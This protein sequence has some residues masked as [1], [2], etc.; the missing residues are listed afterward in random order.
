M[1]PPPP[2][3]KVIFTADDFGLSRSINRA[4]I[5][6]HRDGALT[7][8]SLM[9]GAAEAA[10]A[11]E[12]AR[13]T[14]TLSVGLHI[15]L[16]ADRPVL[17]ANRLKHLVTPDGMLRPDPAWE[18]IH[19]VLSRRAR[20]ELS[21]EIRAQFE[22]FADTGL[23]LSHVDSHMHMHMHPWI[24]QKVVMLAEEF[25]AAG[26][27]LPH[28]SL[29]TALWHN[30]HHLIARTARASVLSALSSRSLRRMH[31]S[32][33]HVTDRCLGIAQSGCMDEDYVIDALQRLDVPAA[34]FVFHPTTGPRI[35]PL[36]ANPGDLRTLTSPRVRQTIGRLGIEMTSYPR[37]DD[38]HYPCHRGAV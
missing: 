20:M 32:P 6:A 27:R 2:I 21:A 35:D 26:I 33:L 10:E 1:L 11:V 29:G 24:F 28:D 23:R 31:Q 12:L 7:S 15:V 38:V 22:R 30:F 37:L 13:Q 14:P 5:R 4:I 36:G 3:R 34:E 18:G 19:L 17:P 9:V 25:G 16:T 8:A